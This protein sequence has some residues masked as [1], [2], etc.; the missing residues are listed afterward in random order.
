MRAACRIKLVMQ[1]IAWLLNPTLVDTN[2]LHS[3][4][5]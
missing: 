2:W 3:A 4:S 5:R 1:V